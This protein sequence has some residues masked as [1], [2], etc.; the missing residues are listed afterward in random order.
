MLQNYTNKN[1]RTEGT[2]GK[3]KYIIITVS[4]FSDY[5]QAMDYYKKFSAEK[6]I[7]NS[8]GKNMMTFI[9]NMENHKL[10]NTDGNP[11]RY[12]LFFLDNYLK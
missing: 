7:R 9:I 6:N 5:T 4:G 12:Q 11:G 2:V 1:Y 3:N 10:F 8:S